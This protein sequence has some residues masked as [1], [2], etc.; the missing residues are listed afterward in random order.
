V[1]FRTSGFSDDAAFLAVLSKERQLRA[2][3][4][5]VCHVVILS[6]TSFSACALELLHLRSSFCHP[7]RSRICWRRR[8]GLNAKRFV[9]RLPDIVQMPV[10]AQVPSIWD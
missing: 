8:G 10:E 2:C 7:D 4:A 5:L 1:P 9:R 6:G 3:P